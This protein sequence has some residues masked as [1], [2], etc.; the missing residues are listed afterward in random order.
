MAQCYEQNYVL[1]LNFTSFSTNVLSL[2][3]HTAFS[4]CVP[5]VSVTVPQA[6]L[7]FDDLDLFE[8]HWSCTLQEV[9]QFEFSGVISWLNS[10]Y[11]L[12]E[13]IPEVKCPSCIISERQDI[14]VLLLVVLTLVTWL[15]WH[16]QMYS[17]ES[18]YFSI[19]I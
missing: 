3:H 18:S 14:A 7:V 4:C 15:R 11:T 12:L 6:S 19:C 17:L 13:R 2:F 1:Y 16:C 9:P 10:A 8:E 5:L